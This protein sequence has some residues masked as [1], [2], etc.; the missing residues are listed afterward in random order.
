MKRNG[1]HPP[2]QQC[3]WNGT[4]LPRLPRRSHPRGPQTIRTLPLPLRRPPPGRLVPPGWAPPETVKS[5]PLRILPKIANSKQLFRSMPV[6]RAASILSVVAGLIAMSNHSST[7]SRL[8]SYQ[9]FHVHC[10]ILSELS[11]LLVNVA[12]IQLSM[13]SRGP[14]K[15]LKGFTRS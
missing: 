11:E 14:Y 10:P 8:P 1:W 2:L 15:A 5:L 4:A 3:R 6:V 13:L 12:A 9:V 7:V